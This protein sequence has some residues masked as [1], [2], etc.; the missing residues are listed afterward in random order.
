MRLIVADQTIFRGGVKLLS[1][2]ISYGFSTGPAILEQ[3]QGD[4]AFSNTMTFPRAA[5][6]QIRERV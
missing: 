5:N 2:G 3:V 4:G 6:A 1:W